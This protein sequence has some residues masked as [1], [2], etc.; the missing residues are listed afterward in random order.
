M[1]ILPKTRLFNQMEF[2][3]FL[4]FILIYLYLDFENFI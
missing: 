1:N 3:L 4:M 2:I